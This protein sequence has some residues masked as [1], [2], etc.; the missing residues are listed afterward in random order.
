[1]AAAG[2]EAAQAMAAKRGRARMMGAPRRPASVRRSLLD[3][4]QLH[5]EDERRATGDGGRAALVAVRDRR[6][7]DELGLAPDLQLRD[8]LGPALDDLVER[9]LRRLPALH[10][11]VEDLSIGEGAGVVHLDRVGLLRL[12]ARALRDG[13]E[14][15][16]GGRLL[17]PLLLGR[18]LE[19]V[20]RLL[21]LLLGGHLHARLR[22]LVDL[23]L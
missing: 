18:L 2:K 8:A 14:D 4:E 15:E 11:A 5:L 10:G 12:R 17:G 23:L 13:H 20:L 7:A 16:S 22:E 19:E 6:R 3:L 21:L 1:M 9:E